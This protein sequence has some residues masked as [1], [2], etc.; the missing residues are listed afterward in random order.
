MNNSNNLEKVMHRST[1]TAC[2]PYKDSGYYLVHSFLTGK[3]ALL[4]EKQKEIYEHPDKYASEKIIPTLLEYGFISMEDD[5]SVLMERL[6]KGN[7]RIPQNKKLSLEICPTLNCNF[8]CRYCFEA[9]R[10][11]TGSM[12]DET[13]NNIVEFVKKRI[14]ETKANKLAVKWFGGEPLLEIETIKKLS[15]KLIKVADEYKI[16]YSA[17]IQTNAYL[18]NQE[19]IDVLEEKGVKSIEVTIDGNKDTHDKLR[20]LSGGRGTYEKIIDNLSHIKTKMKIDIRCNLH[21]DNLDTFE[22]LMKDIDRLKQITNNHIVCTPRVIRIKDNLPKDGAFLKDV[23]F[24]NEE[25]LNQFHRL[26][27]LNH[28]ENPSY[29]EIDYFT[30]RIGSPCKACNGTGFTIDELGNIYGCSMEVGKSN[31]VIGNVRTYENDESLNNGNG[32]EFYRNSFCTD[33]EECKNCAV[34][35][36]CLGRC[37]RTWNEYYDCVWV[38]G[39]LSDIMIKVYDLLQ[40]ET[41]SNG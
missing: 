13:A 26:Y 10:R 7:P 19:I 35:P 32:Y 12:N 6:K 14:K 30:G 11:H 33:R 36:I 1:Y 37:P 9:G 22:D 17:F 8:D 38:K 15:D 27:S 4:T 40:N 29:S 24:T 41:S 2:V 5:Y 3:F 34:L 23:A 21:K 18:L 31:C 39:N 28:I 25:F 20:V 16:P